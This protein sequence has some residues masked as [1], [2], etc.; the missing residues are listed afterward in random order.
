MRTLKLIC[1]L[2]LLLLTAVWAKPKYI[3]DYFPAPMGAEWHYDM[4]SDSGISMQIKHVVT[5]IKKMEKGGYEIEMTS[6]SPQESKSY[7]HKVP[8]WVYID[9]TVGASF[10]MDYVKDQNYLMNPLAIGKGWNYKGTASGMNVTQEWKA[11]GTEE[12]T[13]PAG[14]YKTI[15]VESTSD[16][17]G[18]TTKYTFWYADRVG[19]VKIVTVAGGITS[20]SVLTKVVFPKK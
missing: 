9:K 14:K 13:V 15:K 7:Y 2:V 20:T 10:T 3:P 17:A 19:A 8:G 4:T 18:N 11:V 16:M 5:A 12:V 1:P 6:H